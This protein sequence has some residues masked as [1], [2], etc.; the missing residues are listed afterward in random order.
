MNVRLSMV[1]LLAFALSC[2]FDAAFK[3]YCENNPQCKADAGTAGQARD[4]GDAVS[5]TP[6]PPPRTCG[7]TNPCATPFE[8]CHPFG[9][10]CMTTCN[11]PAD[12]PP[13]LDTCT[14]IRDAYGTVYTPKVCT[15]TSAQI[16]NS[17]AS[18]FTCNP[19]DNLCERLCATTQ[20]CVGFQPPRVCDELS[21]LCVVVPP[22]CYSN[23]NCPLAAQPRCDPFSLR[24]TGCVSPSDCAARLDGFTQ[25]SPD[26]SCVSP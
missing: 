23:A 5:A 3:H 18:I 2:D 22:T 14:A 12:C 8:V 11:S 4:G 10:V 21:G 7:P 24:C 25:C 19:S 20:D 13:W 17:Y 15:C 1:A 16:C 26:G 6:I 9:L